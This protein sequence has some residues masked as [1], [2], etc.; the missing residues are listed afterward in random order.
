MAVRSDAEVE[1]VEFLV[2]R[3]TSQDVAIGQPTV[4]VVISPPGG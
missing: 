4:I 1:G 2:L 3:L